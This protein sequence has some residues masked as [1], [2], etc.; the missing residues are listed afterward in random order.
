VQTVERAVER[1]FRAP[2]ARASAMPPGRR[3]KSL[4]YFAQSDLSR[5]YA[6]LLNLRCTAL[7]Q[8]IG[9]TVKQNHNMLE[10]AVDDGDIE[11]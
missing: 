1:P 6:Q 5:A 3:A 9:V 11:A 2:I 8:A 4:V 7:T 10:K